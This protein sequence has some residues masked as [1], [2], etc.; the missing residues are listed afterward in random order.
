MN[1]LNAFFARFED[2]ANQ[3]CDESACLLT[4]CVD[5]DVVLNDWEVRKVFNR[6]K[7]R[8]ACGPDLIKPKVLKLCAPQLTFIY[9]F[10]M[11]FSL[12]THIIPSIWKCSELLPVP[13]RPI[14]QLNDFRPVALTSVVMKCLEK[15]IL[16]RVKTYFSPVQDPFQF[17]YRSGRSVED[18][19]L[20]LLNNIYEHIDKPKGIV[21][22]L[23]LDFSS[24]FNTIKPSI[25]IER[26]KELKVNSHIIQ[27]IFQFL[28]NRSQ[29][30]K[31]QNCVSDTLITNTGSP[32]GC[33]LSP[34]L[35]TIYTNICQINSDVVKLIKF[36]DDSCIQGL[37]F[38]ENDVYNYFNEID[39]F[40]NWCSSNKLL[41]N[42]DKTKELIFDFRTNPTNII[43][44]VINGNV[45]EQVHTYKYLGVVIDD[46]LKWVEQAS[47]VSKKIN[48]RMFFLRKLNSFNV[49]KT[50]LN[51]FYTSTIQSIISF[52]LI[53]WGGNTSVF[54]KKKINRVVKRAE[55][56]THSS[57][58]FFDDLVSFLSLKKINIIE[59]SDHPLRCKIKRSVRSNRPIFIKTRTQ[60]FS[61]S[62]LPSAIKLI[63]FKR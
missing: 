2:E 24:A 18:A 58:C 1:S 22:T 20:L 4:D 14:T 30:V 41:L 60:R 6:L 3:V 56:I 37:I 11:N 19:I 38:T 12:K 61:K 45:I 52:C 62:F 53:A 36:A 27:W 9:T 8:K 40:T 29:Y 51:L 17:A 44:V 59:K 57:F 34:V 13:K 43:P 31:F 10:I 26:L 49:D 46:K 15:L 35:F 25:L 5:E 39:Y 48:K 47:A 7:E 55:K 23:F 33:V 63:D 21:R 50:I 16:L 42:T 32:Q 54:C 28:T